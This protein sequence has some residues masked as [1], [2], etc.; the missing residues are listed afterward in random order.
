[1]TMGE[2][3]LT[4]LE[5]WHQKEEY[6]KVVEAL[7]ELVPE[8]MTDN[9]YGQLARALSYLQRYDEALDAL[10]HVSEEGRDDTW[11]YRRGYALFYLEQYEEA[12]RALETVV[13]INPDDVEAAEFAEDCAEMM[14]RQKNKIPFKERVERFWVEFEDREA[15]LRSLMDE[16]NIEAAVNLADQLLSYAFHD[17]FFELGKNEDRYELVLTAEG[18]RHRLFLLNY[19]WDHAP[20]ALLERWDFHVGRLRARNME[21]WKLQMFGLEVPASEIRV[22]PE[23]IDDKMDVILYSPALAQLLGGQGEAGQRNEDKAYNVAEILLDEALGERVAI[24]TVG[25]LEVLSEPLDEPSIAL[26]DLYEYAKHNCSDWDADP[27]DGFMSYHAVPLDQWRLREDVIAGN[28]CVNKLVNEYYAEQREIFNEALEDGAIFGFLFFNQDSKDPFELIQSR[29]RIEEALEERGEEICRIIG[30]ATGSY[31]NYI[32]V[33]V[34]DQ[35][36]FLTLA[37]EVLNDQKN[38]REMGFS[39]YVMGGVETDLKVRHPEYYTDAELDALEGHIAE[40]FGEFDRVI[41]EVVSPDI[42]VDL[43][44][45]EPNEERDYYTICTMGMGAHRMNVPYNM[46]GHGFDRAELFI[47]LPK[48]WNLDSEEERDYWPL[49]WL[50]ILARMPIQEDT[51]LGFGHTV[52]NKGPFADNTQLSGVILTS[53]AGFGDEAG[54][55]TLPDGTSVTFYRMIP[56]YEEE[57]NYKI[58]YGTE[59]LL[60]LMRDEA[61]DHVLDIHRPNLV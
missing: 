13:K 58:A 30:G 46:R 42:H 10:D 32:D 57:M 18:Q 3:T 6:E 9:L 59:A 34:Y 37:A 55:C 38:L 26:T 44:V 28:S 15:E 43:A 61:I 41:H 22:W 25:G 48:D 2:L 40:H 35:I 45:I 5:Q 16:E 51:W 24:N 56:I 50:K 52:P 49:R 12:R 54:E 7:E 1:I 8:D 27:C 60:D 39:E 23:L 21:Q 29:A 14:L 31:Y 11:W 53:A 17:A 47:T 33:V 20:E 19:W 36:E 4:M